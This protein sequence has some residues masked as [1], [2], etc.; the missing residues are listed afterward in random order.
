MSNPLEPIINGY[1]KMVKDQD[2]KGTAAKFKEAAKIIFKL[3][4]KDDA[5]NRYKFRA[6]FTPIDINYLDGYFIFGTGTNSVVHFH[7]K[8]TPGWKYGIWF[9]DVENAEGP[10]R[11]KAIWFAQFEAEIDKFKPSASMVCEPFFVDLEHKTAFCNSIKPSILFIVEHP[12]LAWYRD[13][14][15]VDY[16]EEYVP[17]SA[18]KRRYELYLKARS[19]GLGDCVHCGGLSTEDGCKGC[20]YDRAIKA[21][22][23]R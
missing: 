23:G 21:Y 12:A 14:H 11:V 3:L 15:F 7:L 22:D 4:R 5:Y 9:S 16:N 8:E 13:I 17:E 18:A 19:E 20:L 1:E 2:E 6:K 10:E